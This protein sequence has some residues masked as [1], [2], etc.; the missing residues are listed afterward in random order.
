MAEVSRDLKLIAE[1]RKHERRMRELAE[2]YKHDIAEST[3][4]DDYFAE[5]KMADDGLY[6]AAEEVMYD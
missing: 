2:E 5:M 6:I 1:I 3:G 4:L